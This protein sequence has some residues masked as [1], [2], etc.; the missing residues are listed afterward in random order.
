MCVER[1]LSIV[2]NHMELFVKMHFNRIL[3]ARSMC[4]S[5]R[6]NICVLWKIIKHGTFSGFWFVRDVE[7]YFAKSDD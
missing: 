1:P 2:E 4:I 6:G 5:R 7:V 3:S